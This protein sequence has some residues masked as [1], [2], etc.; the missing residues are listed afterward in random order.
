MKLPKSMLPILS[1]AGVLVVQT[2]LADD[3]YAYP[4]SGFSLQIYSGSPG[5][6]YPPHHHHHHHHYYHHFHPK[7]QHGHWH[8]R[9]FD[10]YDYTPPRYPPGY[11]YPGLNINWRRFRCD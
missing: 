11:Y 3:F 7:H 5:Y 4:Y 8:P 10:D 1:L 9:H 2:S 6:Y